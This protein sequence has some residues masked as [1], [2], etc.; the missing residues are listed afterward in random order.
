MPRYRGVTAGSL[1]DTWPV[2]VGGVHPRRGTLR[3][4]ARWWRAR[5]AR[6]LPGAFRSRHAV[7][8]ERP[9]LS[10]QPTAV[11][12]AGARRARVCG[13]GRAGAGPRARARLAGGVGAGLFEDAVRGRIPCWA[14]RPASSRFTISRT[15]GSSTRTGCRASI[16]AGTSFPSIGMEYWGRISFLKGG[17]NDADAH[18]DR[19]PAICGR[20]PDAGAGLR[21]RRHPAPSPA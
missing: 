8:A 9:R 20:D 4:A 2:T 14:A 10:R 3:S 11:R 18:H 6:G 17:I 16:W 15:R 12:A 19:Q 1:V 5:V 21:L 7:R 13:A